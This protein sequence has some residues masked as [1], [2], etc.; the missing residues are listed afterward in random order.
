MGGINISILILVLSACA[1]VLADFVDKIFSAYLSL[2]SLNGE[3]VSLLTSYIHRKIS[4]VRVCF[5]SS[6][7][8]RIILFI[9]VFLLIV[10]VMV[11]VK[12][13]SN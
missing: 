11:S 2:V 12:G 3:G 9:I 13:L 10:C 1:Q 8:A 7:L 4:T 6:D 5:E